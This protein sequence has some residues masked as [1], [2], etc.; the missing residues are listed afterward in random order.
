MQVTRQI[1]GKGQIYMQEMCA[2]VFG[3]IGVAVFM[4][5]V[6]GFLYPF[7]NTCSSSFCCPC[8]LMSPRL[9][10]HPF[11]SNHSSRMLSTFPGPPPALR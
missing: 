6:E 3:A 9:P 8:I 2:K 7:L 11:S 10:D 4:V 5:D 1:E